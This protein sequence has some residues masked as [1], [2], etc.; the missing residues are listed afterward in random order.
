M[1]PD[2]CEGCGT[3]VD[4]MEATAANYEILLALANK[5]RHELDEIAGGGRI[6]HHGTAAHVRRLAEELGER[7]DYGPRAD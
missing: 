5:V 1:E 3:D 6:E 4:K 2:L 7:L